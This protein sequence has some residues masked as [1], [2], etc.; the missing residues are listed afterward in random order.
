MLRKPLEKMNKQTLTAMLFVLL[1]FSMLIGMFVNVADVGEEFL[2][3]YRASVSPGSSVIERFKGATSALS[4]SAGAG[5]PGRQEYIELFG[6]MQLAMSK[7]IVIDPNYGAVYKTPDGQVVYAVEEEYIGSCLDSMYTLVNTLAQSKIPLLYVQAPFKL[8][9][10]HSMLPP[11]VTNYSGLNADRFVN[12]LT[13]AN[14]YCFDLRPLLRNSGMTQNELFYKTDHHWT[15]EASFFGTAQ[16]VKKLN[17]DF[18][19]HIDE[20]LYDAE[21][22]DFRKYKDF[23]IGSIGRRVGRIYGG[24]DD[25]TLIT[26][27]FKTEFSLSI[28][29]EAL[30]DG[31]FEDA[32]LNKKFIDKKSPSSTNRYAVYPG[33]YAELKFENHLADDGKIL[34]IKDSFGVPVYS[35]LSIGVHEVRAIDVRLFKGDVCEYAAEYKPDI[36]LL[37]YNEDC[38][39]DK[40]FNFKEKL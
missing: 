25:F 36:V 38:F 3:S 11:T 18:G 2:T 8:P 35:F 39:N 26:P 37:L 27:N 22:Y 21:N 28:D 14:I 30:S 13:G 33:D 19:F 5:V 10:A 34:V 29:G 17:G 4:A 20:S 24:V 15:T 1:I 32:V 12:A 40:L 9:D 31:S 7:K 23:Y 16:I 6:L